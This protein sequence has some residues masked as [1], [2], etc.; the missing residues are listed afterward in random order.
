VER[1]LALNGGRLRVERLKAAFRDTL[2]IELSETALGHTSVSR[3]LKD[4][5]VSDAIELE[6]RPDGAEQLRCRRMPRGGAQP[7]SVY[8]EPRF[9]GHG[10]PNLHD[11]REDRGSPEYHECIMQAGE[12]GEGGPLPSDDAASDSRDDFLHLH[13]EDEELIDRPY[14]Q[15]GAASPAAQKVTRRAWNG[16]GWHHC[17][18]GGPQRSRRQD[19]RRKPPTRP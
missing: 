17:D 19:G 18:R 5:R 6:T 3:M 14:T 7:R 8:G 1:L 4:S 9:E 16:S 13:R 11:G 10:G 12:E 15:D 2:G